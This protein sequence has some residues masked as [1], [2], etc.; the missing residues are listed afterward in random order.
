MGG[1]ILFAGFVVLYVVLT[2]V[3]A[4]LFLGIR[5]LLPRGHRLSEPFRQLAGA[6]PRLAGIIVSGLSI[7]LLAGLVVALVVVTIAYS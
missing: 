2:I 6:S 7:L 5:A 4:G 1:L 3:L